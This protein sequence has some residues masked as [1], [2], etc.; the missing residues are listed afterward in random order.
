[1]P[2]RSM[3]ECPAPG[4]TWHLYA[5]GLRW[6]TRLL[7]RVGEHRTEHKGRW[8][9]LPLYWNPNEGQVGHREAPD[10]VCVLQALCITTQS[11]EKHWRGCL[12][13]SWLDPEGLT[14][15]LAAVLPNH[16]VQSHDDLQDWTGCI[17]QVLH[18]GG[19]GLL[20][21]SAVPQEHH[22]AR[23]H[24]LPTAHWALVL[25]TEWVGGAGE[26]RDAAMVRPSLLLLD[27]ARDPVWG[28]AHNARL[29]LGSQRGAAGKGLLQSLDGGF[30]RIVPSHLVT[31]MPGSS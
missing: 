8:K 26:V 17:H 7:Y 23:R 6:E 11:P 4:C 30:R 25:G 13:A 28:C 29:G 21:W 5:A 10:L 15:K 20:R 22:L 19:L 31:V 27:P 12:D 18:G 2:R 14:R 3:A 16:A 9:L 24:P 1:M